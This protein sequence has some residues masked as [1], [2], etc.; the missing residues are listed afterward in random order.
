[1]WWTLPRDSTTGQPFFAVL[2]QRFK[3]RGCTLVVAEF[4]VAFQFMHRIIDAIA[5][6][7]TTVRLCTGRKGQSAVYGCLAESK[8]TTGSNRGLK[9]TS[10]HKCINMRFKHNCSATIDFRFFSWLST[11]C[12]IKFYAFCLRVTKS[13]CLNLTACG[14]N[15][16][17][18]LPVAETRGILHHTF[19][20]GMKCW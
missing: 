7:Y 15:R 14:Q 18:I 1:M 11:R 5:V 16:A 10:V 8:I 6:Q 3:N 19:R 12:R 4:F 2:M 13:E 20:P 17:I 9:H